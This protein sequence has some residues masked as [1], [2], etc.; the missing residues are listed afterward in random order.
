LSDSLL[1]AFAVGFW[2]VI[3]TITC[4]TNH[5]D[6]G[7]LFYY[8]IYFQLPYQSFYTTGSWLWIYTLTWVGSKISNKIF[9]QFAYD[10]IV[11]SS[12]WAYLSH[13]LF[14]SIAANFII[15]PFEINFLVALVVILVFTWFCL[16]ASYTFFEK[17]R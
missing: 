5:S 13:Y 11:G 12:M 10:L 8:P 3:Y 4:P 2:Y 7:F 15:R 1:A 14:I 9:N 16:F 17:I 6:T